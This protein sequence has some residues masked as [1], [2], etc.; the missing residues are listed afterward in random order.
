MIISSN[1]QMKI[2]FNQL[3]MIPA[4]GRTGKNIINTF[5]ISFQESVIW[6]AAHIW[7][8]QESRRAL[9][10]ECSSTLHWHLIPPDPVQ[11]SL[12]PPRA[13]GP[14]P[15]ASG[16]SRSQR[17]VRFPHHTGAGEGNCWMHFY[18]PWR[19]SSVFI[20][21]TLTSMWEANKSQFCV[22]PP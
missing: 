20:E 16:S 1:V 22:S 21:H 12:L 8:R 18:G 4:S 14:G 3:S 6:V 7:R 10:L 19:P 15:G 5:A 2:I 9:T 17:G 13:P 11:T